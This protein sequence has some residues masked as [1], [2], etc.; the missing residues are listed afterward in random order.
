MFSWS[1]RGSVELLKFCIFPKR[2]PATQYSLPAFREPHLNFPHTLSQSLWQWPKIHRKNIKG[3]TV[4]KG[5][6]R[7]T[8]PTPPPPSTQP[9]VSR[10]CEWTWQH[11]QKNFTRRVS[12]S[13]SSFSFIVPSNEQ[14]QWGVGGGGGWRVRGLKLTAEEKS[15]KL[16]LSVSIRCYH[17]ISEWYRCVRLCFKS[18]NLFFLSTIRISSL[19]NASCRRQQN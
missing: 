4:V 17:Y 13:F 9:K 8:K 16:T 1:T 12:F 10:S 7:W 15:E 5:K 14:I 19:K 3:L 2:K 11:Q 6:G 18:N